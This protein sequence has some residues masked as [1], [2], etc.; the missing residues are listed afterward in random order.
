MGRQTM[1]TPPGGLEPPTFRLTAERAS[2]LRHGG[3]L[4]YWSNFLICIDFDLCTQFDNVIFLHWMNNLK[5][6]SCSN[7][8][9]VK[10]ICGWFFYLEQQILYALHCCEILQSENILVKIKCL[11][12]HNGSNVC[13]NQTWKLHDSITVYAHTKKLRAKSTYLCPNITQKTKQG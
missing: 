3:L 10:E 2:Q 5:I 13:Q 1:D 11:A 7:Q 12:V 8:L 9:L 4:I 6:F